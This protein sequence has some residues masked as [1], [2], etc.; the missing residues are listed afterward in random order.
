MYHI[1]I[2]S[3][4]EGHLGCFP[5][6]S[7]CQQCCKEH[8]CAGIL[9]NMAFCSY[10]PRSGIAGWPKVLNFNEVQL[11]FFLLWPMILVSHL[12]KHCPILDHKDLDLLKWKDSMYLWVPNLQRA[13]IFNSLPIMQRNY[14][15]LRKI[16]WVCYCSD[17][18]L[19]FM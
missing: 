2:H 9:S 12:R 7:Y 5:C 4:V 15:L 14:S 17:N 11:I 13:W 3:S 6:P 16:G 19:K 10:M 8:W 18:L 1:F